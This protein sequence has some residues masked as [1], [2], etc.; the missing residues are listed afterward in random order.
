MFF[1][2]PVPPFRLDLT[3]WALRRRP[4]NVVDRWDGLTYR[5]V[6]SLRPGTVEIAVTQVAPPK[7]PRLSISVL[8][9]PLDPLLRADVTAILERLLG[10]RID[11]RAFYRLASREKQ[12]GDL[13][14]R[15]QGMKP[16][17]YESLFESLIVG[18]ASQQV[19]RVVSI[20]VLNRLAAECGPKISDRGVAAH[21][22]PRP[23][24][25]AGARPNKLRQLGFSRQKERAMT[26]L[27]R[28]LDAEGLSLEPLAILP[29]AEAVERLCGL[30]GVGRWTAEYVLLRGLGRTHVF[31]GDDVGARN[32]LKRWLRL[33]TP[34]DY[35]AVHCALRRW[36]PYAGLIYFLMLLDCLAQA[37]C[38]QE[39]AAKPPMGQTD[40]HQNIKNNYESKS[41]ETIGSTRPVHLAGLHPA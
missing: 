27:A 24:D 18:I 23:Q 37:E 5:R 33:E 31:P 35:E 13:A 34:L 3:V 17:R 20:L 9:Q 28:S 40:K 22:F 41:I 30:P 12:L 6:L 19:S 2:E 10:F 8:G 38:L 15:F 11:L 14:R 16:P 4:E 26:A 39:S 32:N 29:D 1:L 25:L 7:A 21:A 36:R